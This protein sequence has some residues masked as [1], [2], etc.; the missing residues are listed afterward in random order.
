MDAT[1]QVRAFNRVVTRRIG[2]LQA[3]YLSRGRPPG[4]PRARWEI[5]A[6]HDDLRSLRARMDL[7]AGYLTRLV[8]SLERDGLVTLEP[9]PDDR[10]VRSVRLTP[11]GE[12]ELAE[13]NAASDE[14]AESMLAP[15]DERQRERLVGAMGEVER[16]L[17]AGLVQVAPEDPRT[18]A[19]QSCLEA[20][21]AEI[22]ERFEM[23]YDRV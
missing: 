15:L 4:A 8:Q 18:P 12:T 11:R 21:F 10:R 1:D 23:G 13:L 16:L 3:E 7:D 2:A 17:S 14:L 9:H 22:D 20:Y 19:V 6:G 5:A